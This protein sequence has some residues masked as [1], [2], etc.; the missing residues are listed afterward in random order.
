M[1]GLIRN[2]VLEGGG[3]AEAKGHHS[4]RSDWG[5]PSS[6]QPGIDLILDHTSTYRGHPA[7][8][9]CMKSS[10]VPTQT[11]TKPSY[12]TYNLHHRNTA[13][14]YSSLPILTLTH[15]PRSC[16]TLMNVKSGSSLEPIRT[17]L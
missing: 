17:H 4:D 8:R 12:I 7:S 9:S 14:V 2:D 15:R 3:V 11:L 5:G 16:I 10:L 1:F 13:T 6:Q